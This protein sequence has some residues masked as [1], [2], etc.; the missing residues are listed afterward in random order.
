MADIALDG[1]SIDHSV[2]VVN[3]T[4]AQSV[5]GR[6]SEPISGRRS[7]PSHNTA[8]VLNPAA[9][10]TDNGHPG[11]KDGEDDFTPRLIALAASSWRAAETMASGIAYSDR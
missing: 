3:H 7:L 4:P 11:E 1:Q 6:S 2:H 5:T 8:N 9:C 10:A